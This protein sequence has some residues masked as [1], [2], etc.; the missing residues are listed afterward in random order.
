MQRGD[1]VKGYT[2]DGGGGDV[3]GRRW[4]G[5]VERWK[6][7]DEI[8]VYGGWEECDDDDREG[9]GVALAD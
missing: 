1:G 9:Q 2:D 5:G 8:K 7:E 3:T 4:R 6:K